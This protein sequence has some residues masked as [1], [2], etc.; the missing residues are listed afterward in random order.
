[1]A[2]RDLMEDKLPEEKL[3]LL[4]KGYEVVGDI[5]II[6]LPLSLHNEK[7]DIARALAIHRKDLKVVLLK[8]NKI[9]GEKRIGE[10]E[11]LLGDR[12]ET[13]HR[14]NGCIF[15]VDVARTYFSGKMYFERNRVVQEV[16]DG[17]DVLVLFCG[18]GPFLIPI[19]KK[20]NVRITGLDNNPA[21]CALLKKNARLNDIY[22]DIVLGDAKYMNAI[23]R[24]EFD[25]IV[26]P[27]PYG[28]DHFLDRAHLLLRPGGIIHFYTFK[29]DFEISHFRRVLE[30]RGWHIEFYRECGDIA[31][32]VKRYVFDLKK[33]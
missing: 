18:V 14:E 11:I 17:E 9:T 5:A 3:L 22:T 16:N 1:M 26:M 21:A 29:K 24:K 32:R 8:K 20:K 13:F 2:L 27:A 6:N 19:R 15:H 28:Q 33:K 31:P 23:F 25:R 10:F 30:E 12:T 4:P 7:Y